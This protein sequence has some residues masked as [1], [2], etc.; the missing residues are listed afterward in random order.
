MKITRRHLAYGV[1]TYGLL[2]W[3]FL[4]RPAWSLPS[5]LATADLAAATFAAKGA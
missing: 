4:S 2:F 5:C 1:W 3:L